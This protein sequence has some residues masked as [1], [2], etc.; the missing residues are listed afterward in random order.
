[1]GKPE[2]KRN[3]WADLGV[4]WRIILKEISGKLD[5]VYWIYLCGAVASTW[6]RRGGYTV[7]VGKTKGKIL[8][9]RPRVHGRIILKWIL[10]IG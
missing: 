9:P 4:D 3:H 2:R 1:V 5:E 8:L 10:K 7:L 6:D